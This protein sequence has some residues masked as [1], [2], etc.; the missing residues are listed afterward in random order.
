MNEMDYAMENG[1]RNEVQRI[2]Y[3]SRPPE[4]DI[5]LA[6]KVRCEALWDIRNTRKEELEDVAYDGLNNYVCNNWDRDAIIDYHMGTIF[7]DTHDAIYWGIK[8]GSSRTKLIN[9]FV[10]EQGTAT[11]L[12]D[13]NRIIRDVKRALEAKTRDDMIF[14]FVQHYHNYWNSVDTEILYEI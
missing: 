11:D 13:A 8:E 9:Y 2:L 14:A 6:L 10:N 12:D 4:H 1:L 5:S 7:Q 3:T